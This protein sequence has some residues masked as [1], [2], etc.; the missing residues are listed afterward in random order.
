MACQDPGGL[1]PMCPANDSALADTP[2]TDGSV[3]LGQDTF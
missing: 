3:Y 1:M 2:L